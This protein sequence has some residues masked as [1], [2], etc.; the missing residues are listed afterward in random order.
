MLFYYDKLRDPLKNVCTYNLIL[1]S[2]LTDYANNV[3][4]KFILKFEFNICFINNLIM[5]IFVREM[6]RLGLLKCTLIS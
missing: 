5:I 1:V 2:H 3:Y 4:N 6:S